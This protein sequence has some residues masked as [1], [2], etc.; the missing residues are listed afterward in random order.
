[1][2]DS[3]P[4]HRNQINKQIELTDDSDD[5]T[6]N[7]LKDRER[8][9]ITDFA[10]KIADK[11]GKTSQT[12]RDTIKSA[13]IDCYYNVVVNHNVRSK[14]EIPKDQYWVKYEGGQLIPD[15]NP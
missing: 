10:N 9:D 8:E 3:E 11:Y 2:S 12:N 7:N 15:N 5:R 13:I 14:V 6:S 1:M 4:Q